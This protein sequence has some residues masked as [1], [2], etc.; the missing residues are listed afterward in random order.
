MQLLGTHND[1]WV[2]FMAHALL[3]VL[4]VPA[5][6]QVCYIPE[7][8]LLVAAAEWA[9]QLTAVPACLVLTLY[10]THANYEME[11]QQYPPLY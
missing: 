1:P 9:A 7:T 2:Q 5:A 6:Y 4:L 8:C 3:K 10:T 11:I